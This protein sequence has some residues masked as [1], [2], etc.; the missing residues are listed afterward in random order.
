MI[1]NNEEVVKVSC[2]YYPIWVYKD[3]IWALI[4]NKSKINVIGS[5]CIQMLGSKVRKISIGAQK[6]DFS[7]LKTFRIIIADFQIKNKVDK[8]RYF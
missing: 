1:N 8:A 5:N 2:I 7:T 6:I 3:E 4:K